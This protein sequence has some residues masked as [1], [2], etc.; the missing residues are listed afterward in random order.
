MKNHIIL[1][2]LLAITLTSCTG[3]KT[4]V[5][6]KF[7]GE[8]Q[9]T[10]Y[11]VTYYDSKGISYQQ[12]IDSF[13]RAFDQSASI[14]QKESIISRLNNND[15]TARADDV[16][17]YVFNKSM[18]VS[19]K[20]DGAFDITVLPLV[21]AW[22]FGFTD[23]MKLDSSQV[24]SILPLVNYRNVKLTDGR[25]VKTN[26]A[27]KVD[28]NAIAQG[29]SADLIGQ[30]LESHGIENYLIDVGGE[31]LARGTKPGNIPWKV[32]IEKPAENA[33]DAR[34]LNTVV[35]LSNKALATSGNYRKYFIRDG[36]RYS[37][38]IDPKTG[39]PVNHTV[40]SVSVLADDCISADAY[41][42]SFIVMG[43]DKTKKF[44]AQHPELD[45]YIIYSDDS[46]KLTTWSSDGLS[47]LVE[48]VTP[49][50]K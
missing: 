28:F 21:N 30:L 45:A 8:A 50:E 11:A 12:D 3:N 32:G 17:T 15:S 44:L 14:Y 48:A 25:L 7:E 33:D 19:E 42:T 26:P 38:T 34:E 39:F 43:L 27:I 2:I 16:F 23:P 22:G 20:T 37:H 29:Y 40:L 31:V 24:D 46:G 49:E 4:L 9:G 47:Q 6:V 13:F 36:V 10:Y 1:F 41:A 18:E 5:E 35:N